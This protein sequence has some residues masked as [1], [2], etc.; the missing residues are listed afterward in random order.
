MDISWLS[1]ARRSV[2][3]WR[4]ENLVAEAGVGRRGERPRWAYSGMLPEDLIRR[5]GDAMMPTPLGFIF[6]V[7]CAV[8]RRYSAASMAS[9][10]ST[11]TSPASTSAETA[12]GQRVSGGPSHLTG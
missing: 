4:C 9:A 6:L 1:R 7:L 5:R 10:A 2:C 12:A 3:S 11:S 8:D